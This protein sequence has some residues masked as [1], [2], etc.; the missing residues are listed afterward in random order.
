MDQETLIRGEYDMGK[1]E[2]MKNVKGM[3]W[4]AHSK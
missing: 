3:E 1:N 4:Q 2:N